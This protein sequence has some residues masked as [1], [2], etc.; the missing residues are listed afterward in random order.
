ME[1][2]RLATEPRVL[3]PDPYGIFFTVPPTFQRTDDPPGTLYP[4]IVHIH[5]GSFIVGSSHL[6]P[7][8]ALASMQ[9]VVVTFNYRLGAFGKTT[10][11]SS[12]NR[13]L[14]RNHYLSFAPLLSSHLKCSELGN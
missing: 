14:S 8:H 13:S 11:L 1:I 4:V 9:V 6:Y 5:G 10:L 2:D 3:S 12:E 7:G